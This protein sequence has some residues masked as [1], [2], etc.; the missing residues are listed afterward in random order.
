M[1]TEKT[2]DQYFIDW[3][4]DTFGCGYGDGEAHILPALKRFLEL[5]PVDAEN[6]HPCSYDY[7]TLEKELTPTVAWLLINRLCRT[8]ILTYGTSSRVAR[9]TDQGLALKRYTADK[10]EDELYD[11]IADRD[12]SYIPCYPDVCNCGPRGS[13]EGRNCDNPFWSP[14]NPALKQLNDQETEHAD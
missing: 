11:I 10:T 14:P 9:L 6:G 7:T 4:S 13:I 8:Q 2:L 5:C 3:E 12:F 1:N